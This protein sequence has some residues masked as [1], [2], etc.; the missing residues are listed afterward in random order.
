M[1]ELAR[2]R[3]AGERLL[4]GVAWAGAAIVVALFTLLV[5]DLARRGGGELSW[6]YLVEE[7]RD[8]GRSGGIA[9][10]LVGTAGLL[11]LA[12]G[13][14]VP[15]ALG[16]AIFL[17]DAGA[18]TAS[19]TSRW[20]AAAVRRSLEL[21]GGVPSI[22][23]GLFGNALFCRAFGLGY[24]MLAGGATLACMVLPL[25]TAAFDDGF[26]RVP[27][28]DRAAAAASALSRSTT[29]RHVLLPRALPLL[30]AGIVW[31]VARALAETAALLF[32]SGYVDR[33][34]TSLLDSTRSLSVHV[35]DLAMNV[36]GG[37]A[38]ACS[39]ALLLLLLVFA[40]QTLARGSLRW[41]L[42]DAVRGSPKEA[43]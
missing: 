9:S 19:R 26:R 33:M 43:A 21:L 35:W 17:D 29:L 22:V 2:G 28:A 31:S 41:L 14:A 3:Q 11:A 1:R 39:A 18:A 24:S 36:A 13:F 30:V 16:T 32:T 37:D 42:R 4:A 27:S 40:I 34:P 7:P 5:V 25:M 23:F 8:A 6:N 20:L 10:V 38:R 12:I 15:L